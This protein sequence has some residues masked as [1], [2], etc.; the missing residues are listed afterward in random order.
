VTLIGVFG[1]GDTQRARR[2]SIIER[3]REMRIV[4]DVTGHLVD[5]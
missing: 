3:E 1:S 2:V 5:G 4:N